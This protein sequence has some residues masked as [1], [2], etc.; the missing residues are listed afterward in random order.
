MKG[1][2]IRIKDGHIIDGE[3]EPLGKD[4]SGDDH[5]FWRMSGHLEVPVDLAIKLELE[6]PQRFE[7]VDR[8]LAKSFTKKADEKKEETK[9]KE[10]SV[11]K[12]IDE[13]ITLE[14]LKAKTK[15]ELNDWAAKRGYDVN[16]GRQLKGGM[17]KRLV[18]QI[19]L[20]RLKK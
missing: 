13:V 12:V 18:K 1:I 4:S 11:E 15:D 16:P 10:K 8:E 17:V 7:L 5:T 9:D 3:G 14:E 20:R 19:K 2:L 6:R